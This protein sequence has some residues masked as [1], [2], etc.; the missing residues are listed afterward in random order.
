[1]IKDMSAL[2]GKL[3]K[4]I[5]AIKVTDLLR[6]KLHIRGWNCQGD[7]LLKELDSL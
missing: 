6:G 1:M 5:G 4:P 7:L 2:K 3:A